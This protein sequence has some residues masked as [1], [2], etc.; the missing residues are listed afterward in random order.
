MRADF[1]ATACEFKFAD[2]RPGAFEGYG[3]VFG[4][5]DAYGDVI[6]KGAFKKSLAEWKRRKAL[7]PMLLQH[8]G[9]G[10]MGGAAEDMI[11]VGKW[12]DLAEDETGLFVKGELI[13]LDTD[14]GRRV[15]AAMKAG[16]M[17]GLSIGF[18]ARKFTMGTKP[19]QPRRM[20]EDVDLV[21]VSLVTFPAND[22]ARVSNVKSGAPSTVREF[23][24][25]MRDA[26]LSRKEA[27]I[28]IN[29][30]VKTLLATRDAG[31]GDDEA[32]GLFVAIERAKAALR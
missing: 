27:G 14:I 20:L 28:V 13:A 11:P 3:A 4:N 32:N 25:L 1:L 12:D 17:S 8:G 7:P 15:H 23:E 2:D 18:R 24:A 30:G 16:A 9:G 21:E 10:L 19:D 22:Q 29:S 26:G 5:L 6:Q 31:G